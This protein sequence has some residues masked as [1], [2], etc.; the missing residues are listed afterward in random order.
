M[1]GLRQQL[2]DSP[3]SDPARNLRKDGRGQDGTDEKAGVSIEAKA[4]FPDNAG[5]N[6]LVVSQHTLL[7]AGPPVAGNN[8][9][10][11]PPMTPL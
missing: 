6:H 10:S 4:V 7:A 2:V 8:Q 1:P 9:F 5:S 3:G 11:L